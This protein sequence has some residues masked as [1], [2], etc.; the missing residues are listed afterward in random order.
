MS[1]L[2]QEYEP[3]VADFFAIVPQAE[4]SFNV[5]DSLD[6]SLQYQLAFSGGKDSHALLITYLLWRQSRQRDLDL[7]VV[8]S[9]TQ[10][11]NASLYGLIDAAK[12][13][14]KRE[15]IEFVQVTPSIDQSFWV[16]QV[17]L[18]YPVPDHQ[19]RW[20]TEYL[21]IQPMKLVGRQ[22]IAGSHQGESAKRDSRLKGC[23]SSECGIDVLDNKTEPIAT[24]TNCMVWDLILLLG[25]QVL[26][27][28]ASKVLSDV[29]EIQDGSSSLRFG[30]FMCPV[31]GADRIH[32]QVKQGV[33]PSIATD[34][35]ALL[36]QL[37]CAP[38]I[39]SQKKN[40]KGGDIT[41]AILVDARIEFWNQLQP[42]IP[43]M[44]EYGWITDSIIEKV[45]TLLSKRSYPPSYKLEWIKEQEPFAKP[46]LKSSL[47]EHKSIKATD[48]SDERFSLQPT[49]IQNNKIKE[50]FKMDLSSMMTY[51]L[52]AIQG[53]QGNHPYFVAQVPYGVLFNI[54]VFDESSV[55]FKNQGQRP[56][57]NKRVNEIAE[58]V[59]SNPTDYTFNSLVVAVGTD[60]EFSGDTIGVLKLPIDSVCRIVDGQ[61]RWNGIKQAIQENPSLKSDTISVV[62]FLGDLDRVRQIFSDLNQFAKK[63]SKST[64]I[65]FDGRGEKAIIANAL[66]NEIPLF[67]RYVDPHA[68]TVSPSS[69]KLFSLNHLYQAT[70]IYLSS[71]GLDT[72]QEKKEAALAFWSNVCEYMIDWKQVEQKQVAA[73]ELKKDNLCCQ[74][75]T[76]LAIAYLGCEMN[77]LSVLG[78]LDWSKS[79]PF[80]VNLLISE[81]GRMLPGK[82]NAQRAALTIAAQEAI[83]A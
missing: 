52:P 17:G 53:K 16:K 11:E 5:F 72:V 32:D 50:E 10:L 57:D 25:D 56:L 55:S 66:F 22:V 62:F 65:A 81:E 43:Q 7:A 58:Y 21:K 35:R 45:E 36:E 4:W 61:H 54:C 63:V 28:G 1:T 51:N 34:I 18:G 24:W 13:V 12:E 14:C 37:R 79:N 59:I 33:V 73:K 3:T 71:T 48:L 74:G 31:V 9:D 23:G 40:K 2:I 15:N 30:C 42:Y 38:R 19:N 27:E 67:R 41:G 44:K 77:D 20:C 46:W 69:S 29:Y 75:V 60:V 8:F 78:R 83:D 76:L 49:V 70:E 47:F 6:P 39:L 26:Y 64:A 68:D 82:K 80:W